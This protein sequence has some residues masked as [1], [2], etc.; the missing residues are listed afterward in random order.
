MNRYK[1][2]QG[3]RYVPGVRIPGLWG[4]PAVSSGAAEPDPPAS[5]IL[6]YNN[7]RLIG[8]F[9]VPTFASGYPLSEQYGGSLHNGTSYGRGNTL[10]RISG[11]THMLFH[12]HPYSNCVYEVYVP[13]DASLGSG[14][15]VNL[16]PQA[17]LYKPWGAVWHTNAGQH[18]YVRGAGAATV[19]LQENFGL[20]PH[21]YSGWTVELLAGVAS[22]AT[23]S[24]T[25]Y[26]SPSR[27]GDVSPAWAA[28]PVSGDQYI[29][30]RGQTLSGGD[31][32]AYLASGEPSASGHYHYYLLWCYSGVTGNVAAGGYVY[33]Y[34]GTVR[35]VETVGEDW[36]GRL[37][38]SGTK[39]RLD[40]SHRWTYSE[41]WAGYVN[42]EGA[43]GYSLYYDNTD[44]RLYCNYGLAYGNTSHDPSMFYAI[45]DDETSTACPFGPWLI[46][47]YGNRWVRNGML[48]L[49]S[50]FVDAY[51]SG[52]RLGW[53]VGGQGGY[54]TIQAA[55]VGPVIFAI[56][57]PTS[58]GR[59]L[60]ALSGDV[61]GAFSA[62][63]GG[64][65]MLGSEGDGDQ[66]LNT[67]DWPAQRAPTC[68]NRDPFYSPWSGFV[69][70]AENRFYSGV[71][72]AG[73]ATTIQLTTAASATDDYY[74][75]GKITLTA[76]SGAPDVLLC[77]AYTAADQTMTIY[78]TR[79][80][81]ASS[82]TVL[83]VALGNM[84]STTDSTGINWR[85]DWGFNTHLL[86]VM[87]GVAS[88][89]RMLMSFNDV[90]ERTFNSYSIWPTP[91][92]QSGDAVRIFGGYVQSGSTTSIQM[93][94]GALG[95]YE[96]GALFFA[97]RQGGA[98]SGQE[99]RLN[100]DTIIM[101]S[102]GWATVSPAWDVAPQSGDMYQHY[103]L[104]FP[105]VWDVRSGIGYFNWLDH[106]GGAVHIKRSG[107][108]GVVF[109]CKMAM[110]FSHYE[111]SDVHA[112]GGFKRYLHVY[113]PD[114][115]AQ[116]AL[117]NVLQDSVNPAAII[118]MP[119]YS[120]ETGVS[121]YHG[122]FTSLDYDP[123]TGRMYA[124]SA[125]TWWDGDF[126]GSVA[127]YEVVSG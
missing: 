31:N 67:H 56:D 25:S 83:H 60:P 21:Y 82:G 51:L 14:T 34:S 48:Q 122:Y 62:I 70:S 103:T 54:S 91:P 55:S 13:D 68:R 114:E 97:I 84:V 7:F 18:K 110:E 94:S 88:G 36:S 111:A 28:S 26:D 4:P 119:A 102:G 81:A 107:W 43:P 123:N 72:W 124:Y 75:G 101:E 113:D 57:P 20:P 73:T 17:T 58:G 44:H 29:M 41:G 100:T 3:V 49:E 85:E 27:Q 35:R 77:L 80:V 78:P 118:E 11:E 69:E 10:R 59:Y 66:D 47:G 37:P 125:N 89:T 98:R 1:L 76:G 86:E 105:G 90:S 53:G 104:G 121:D 23:R 92:P 52:K 9:R 22:G 33:G 116:A 95:Y 40:T 74:K 24:M 45:L 42:G 61:S 63:T 46:D 32:Y 96:S 87:T 93:N 115:L 71:A 127:V 15:D 5:G 108:H 126:K 19:T 6:G 2:M 65:R 106:V 16:W 64:I 109:S 117:G 30:W 50:G 8:G 79:S 99:E 120:G 112:F 38:V 39:Y 12:T